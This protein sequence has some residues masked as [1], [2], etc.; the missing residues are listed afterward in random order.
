[1]NRF[2]DIYAPIIGRILM[3]GYFLW[4]GIEMSL[5]FDS[6]SQLLVTTGLPSPLVFAALIVAIEVLGGIALIVGFK[7]SAIAATLAIFTL[8]TTLLSLQID[9]EI[10]V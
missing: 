6:T 7:S 9:N 4:D 10:S 5:N 2:S 3:G 1:M 8:A